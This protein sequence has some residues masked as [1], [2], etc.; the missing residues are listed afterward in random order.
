MGLVTRSHGCLWTWPKQK[1]R[2]SGS[3]LRGRRVGKRTC[4]ARWTNQRLVHVAADIGWRNDDQYYFDFHG[5]KAVSQRTR[6]ATVCRL[7]RAI[8]PPVRVPALLKNNPLIGIGCLSLAG[9]LVCFGLLDWSSSVEQA[10]SPGE[11]DLGV[12]VLG[13]M[14]GI[15]AFFLGLAGL[16]CLVAGMCVWAYRSYQRRV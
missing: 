15:P 9:A 6:F 4:T 13:M 12:A 8:I 2:A 5:V 3:T 14:F 11:K 7:G 16:L 10:S 1:E